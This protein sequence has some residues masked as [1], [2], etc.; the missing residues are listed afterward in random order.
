MKILELLALVISSFRLL[1]CSNSLF[2]RLVVTKVVNATVS[3]DTSPKLLAS[4]IVIYSIAQN[5]F[6]MEI[7]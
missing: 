7:P 6:S 2:A 1:A 3:S 4:F 5:I